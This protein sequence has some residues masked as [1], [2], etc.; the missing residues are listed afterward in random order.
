MARLAL[1]L[2]VIVPLLNTTIALAQDSLSIRHL[3]EM[4]NLSEQ[5]RIQID[6][7]L[8]V[9]SAKSGLI[10]TDIS[11]PSRPVSRN[12]LTNLEP[13]GWD[14][15]PPFAL[16]GDLLAVS[17]HETV[18]L[19]RIH[20]IDNVELLDQLSF[21]DH[22]CWGL[23]INHVRIVAYVSMM[24]L[25]TINSQDPTD[26][27]LI[28][29]LEGRYYGDLMLSQFLTFSWGYDSTRIVNIID[30]QEP[31]VLATF[32][33]AT[34]LA[35][36]NDR[37]FLLTRDS[38]FIHD[39]QDPENPSLLASL[40]T[41]GAEYRY[42][43]AISVEGNRLAIAFDGGQVKLFD[44]TDELE[45]NELGGV[46]TPTR[47]PRDCQ[48]RG[49]NIFSAGG[50]YGGVVTVIDA[51]DPA[52]M[53]E[54]A[55]IGLVEDN[56]PICVNDYFIFPSDTSIITKYRLV[57]DEFQLVYRGFQ[58]W[59]EQGG[60]FGGGT[61]VGNVV[62]DAFYGIR[63]WDCSDP[64]DIRFGSTANWPE[65]E[66]INRFTANE[67]FA[68]VVWRDSLLEIFS[69]ENQFDPSQIGHLEFSRYISGIGLGDSLLFAAERTDSLRMMVID[70]H[71]PQNISVTDSVTIGDQRAHV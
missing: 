58:D 52:N 55:E 54:V 68:G 21:E 48:I 65:N 71:D 66:E 26:L 35:V 4:A 47:W 1:A 67:S 50:V 63:I 23:A 33:R 30:P 24:G 12:I 5:P 59:D 20:S 29:R 8:M 19:Y 2:M 40:T 10:V 38:L 11:D 9:V 18:F 62:Y 36:D 27:S 37:L 56:Y 46:N 51:A 17:Y 6:G 45:L 13:R 28:G 32:R 53:R 22:W 70:L 49:D 25:Y 34:D 43:Q 15:S 64:L 7:S 42:S 57:D 14:F 39:I 41:R 61:V 69:T 16:Y 3:D 60:Y 31:R 44:L